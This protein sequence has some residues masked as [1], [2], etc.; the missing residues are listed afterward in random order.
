M[1]YPVT[2]VGTGSF[3]QVLLDQLRRKMT[4]MDPYSDQYESNPAESQPLHCYIVDTVK[5]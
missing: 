4:F 5:Y 2:V 3:I 1:D